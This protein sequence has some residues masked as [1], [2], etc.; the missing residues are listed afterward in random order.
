MERAL[1]DA[2]A[3]AGLAH[4]GQMDKSGR[5]YVLH[6]IRVMLRCEPHGRAV[7]MA[8][9]LHD[10]V[11]D[12]WVTLDLLRTMGFPAEVVE[13][14]DAISRRKPEEGY[15]AYI[16]RCSRNRIAT[17]VKLADLEDNSDPNRRFGDNWQETMAKYAKARDVLLASLNGHSA[18]FATSP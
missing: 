15:T 4:T 18:A 7:Q 17:L 1:S 11:E 14:V 16:D 8:A 2:I 10:V 6:P 9:A 5:E 3:L 12:T 13:A